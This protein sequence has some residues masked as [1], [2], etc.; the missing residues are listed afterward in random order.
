MFTSFSKKQIYIIFLLGKNFQIYNIN[1]KRTVNESSVPSIQL[2]Q[3]S[4]RQSY[5]IHISTRVPLPYSQVILSK[6]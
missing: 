2:Q 5:L 4:N 6:F 1:V 3:L